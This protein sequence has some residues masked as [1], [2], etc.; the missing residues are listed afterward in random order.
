M[1]LVIGIGYY[2]EAFSMPLQIKLV[3]DLSVR[4]SSKNITNWKTKFF[5]IKGVTEMEQVYN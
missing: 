3:K 4:H 1:S 2:N 5:K